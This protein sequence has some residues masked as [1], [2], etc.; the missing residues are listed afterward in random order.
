M[1]DRQDHGGNQTIT[2]MEYDSD[3]SLV[4]SDY[5]DDTDTGRD[6]YKSDTLYDPTHSVDRRIFKQ[7]LCI[8]VH[9][10][11]RRAQDP[12]DIVYDTRGS[13]F[14]GVLL[15]P[16]HACQ[17]RIKSLLHRNIERIDILLRKGLPWLLKEET[18]AELPLLPLLP[19]VIRCIIASMLCHKQPVCDTC[20]RAY[21]SYEARRH[22]VTYESWRNR[23]TNC[24][25][26]WY[27]CDRN[28]N[29]L[30]N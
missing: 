22:S 18:S 10:Q 12:Q 1:N 26:A 25:K 6:D 14:M 11:R 8:E 4:D 2:N 3:D 5:P 30:L 13:I 17:R 20:H 15:F 19:K 9:P 7:I 29:S 24:L 28:C 16:A 23:C 27:C 21:V